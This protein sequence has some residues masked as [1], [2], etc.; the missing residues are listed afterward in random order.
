MLE[1]RKFDEATAYY[2]QALEFKPDFVPAHINLGN[3]FL[4]RWQTVEAVGCY[5]SPHVLLLRSSYT[6]P[7]YGGLCVRAQASATTK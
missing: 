3:T 7:G 2:R 6:T 5:R 4:S 1:Q